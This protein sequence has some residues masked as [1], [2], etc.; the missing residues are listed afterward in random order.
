MPTMLSRSSW[1]ILFQDLAGEEPLPLLE[2]S[3]LE[4]RKVH[5]REF[6][7]P[8]EA[9]PFGADAFPEAQETPRERP[10]AQPSSASKMMKR[11]NRAIYAEEEEDQP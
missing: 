4:R 6:G 1:A 11:R 2:M 5:L 8:L 7:S 10:Q 3:S 9:A